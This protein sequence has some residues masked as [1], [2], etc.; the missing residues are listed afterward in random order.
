MDS[1]RRK[2]SSLLQLKK[3]EV[4]PVKI[5]CEEEEQTVD[6]DSCH[7]CLWHTGCDTGAIREKCDVEG[8]IWHQEDEDSALVEGE[9]AEFRNILALDLDED[10]IVSIADLRK[11]LNALG[12]KPCAEA[13]QHLKDQIDALQGADDEESHQPASSS[14]AQAVPVGYY[15]IGKFMVAAGKAAGQA[16]KAAEDLQQSLAAVRTAIT[17][18]TDKH[19]ESNMT[20]MIQEIK[21]SQMFQDSHMLQEF[22]NAETKGDL[23]SMD[24]GVP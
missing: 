21:N 22:G 17:G 24:I 4:K 3:S 7:G 2:G 11:T 10:G 20:E 8:G 16:A 14:L 15:L 1:V 13:L 18:K 19:S 5:L 6:D 12:K 9:I 23:Q